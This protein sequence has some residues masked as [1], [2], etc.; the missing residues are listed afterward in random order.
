MSLWKMGEFGTGSTQRLESGQ[1]LV[2]ITVFPQKALRS[3]QCVLHKAEH[4]ASA[5]DAKDC[6]GI[7]LNAEWLEVFGL[8]TETDE[9]NR[10]LEFSPDSNDRATTAG[11]VELCNNK[12]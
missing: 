11:A 4:L 7:V 8:L 9:V 1:Q 12:P 5:F 2:H 3:P 10:Q 6:T